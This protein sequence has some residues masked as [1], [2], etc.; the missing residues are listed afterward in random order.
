LKTFVTGADGMLGTNVV[1]ELLKRKH[2]LV[3]LVH[4]SSKSNT[5]KDLPVSIVKGDILNVSSFESYLSDCNYVV[6]IAA[7]TSVWPRRNEMVNR[8]NIEGTRNL[9]TAAQRAGIQ[10]FVHV[11]SANSMDPGTKDA[12]GTEENA[13]TGWKYKNDYLDSKYK[14]QQMLLNEYE[15][16]G[17]PVVIVSP[18]FMLGEY[19][20]GPTSG[21]LLLSMVEGKV[22]GY[23]K[24]V[25][26]YVHAKDVAVAIA[27]A[28]TLGRTGQV[29][30]AGNQNLDYQTFFTKVKDIAG[31]KKKLIRIPF[32][33]V[34][35]GG[36]F[37]SLLARITKKKPGLSYGMVQLM[38]IEQYYS[39]AKAVKELEM[40][41][42]DVDQAIKD[43]L[44][45]FRANNVRL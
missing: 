3:C 1:L 39:S 26:N 4:P 17:F 23:S 12:P 18:T 27:N 25:K 28:L 45:W 30:I 24:G 15:K 29:Y 10:R 40:P 5:L 31:I 9:M 32:L 38:G 35:M 37:S 16:N 33:L 2:E 42:T 41:Q 43:C 22:P 36:F 14:T 13:Y 8:V 20:S 21:Q 19:D 7:S 44:N 6:H 11:G 34:L